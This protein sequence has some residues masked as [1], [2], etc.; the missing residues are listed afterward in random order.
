MKA[1]LARGADVNAKESAHDQTALMWAAAERHPEVVR[2]LI[3]FGA[4]VRAR[5]L[6]YPQTVVGEQTQ[7]AGR[8]KLNYTVQRG[9]MTPLLF[10]ARSGDV[11]S[12][13]SAAGGGA[14]AN[15]PCRTA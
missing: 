4:D 15:D 10:A 1:L 5:S 2:M 6:V 8:E 7:R 9:G 3:E 14:D 11:E 13:K 12:A